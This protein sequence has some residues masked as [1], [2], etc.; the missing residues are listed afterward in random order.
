[1]STPQK[2]QTHTNNL[3]AF[4]EGLSMFHY[5]NP[6]VMMFLGGMKMEHWPEMD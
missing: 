6:D 1:M 5:F 3:W 2:G 4:A